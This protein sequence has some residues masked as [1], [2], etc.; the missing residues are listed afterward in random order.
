MIAAN[1]LEASVAA[2][3]P[4]AAA[5]A[6]GRLGHWRL[7]RGAD[8]QTFIEGWRT[9]AEWAVSTQPLVAA[10]FLLRDVAD[11]R[12]FIGWWPFSTVEAYVTFRDS[13]ELKS[14]L[15]PL[16]DMLERIDDAIFHL[17][18]TPRVRADTPHAGAL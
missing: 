4:F 8:A 5:P 14:R 11:E 18:A 15:A 9:V 16:G 17:A 10:P 7:K 2:W 1:P 3:A 12:M 13:P 6:I